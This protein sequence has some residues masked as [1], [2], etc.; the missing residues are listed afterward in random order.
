M[1]QDVIAHAI[2][3]FFSTKP[4]GA[5]TGLGLSMIYGF[6]KQSGGHLKIYSEAGVGTTVRLYLPRSPGHDTVAEDATQDGVP[7]AG[8]T[9][10]ILLVDDKAELCAIAARQLS[11][12]GYTTRIAGD[13]PA[14][15][16][17]LRS[18]ERFDLLFTDVVMPGGMNGYQLAAIARQLRPGIAVLFTTGYARAPNPGSV[19]GESPHLLSKPYHRRQ[20]AES[21]RAALTRP[22]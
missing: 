17:L 22:C 8:G 20:L 1:T 21:I 4:P 9:E 6:A 5:G 11:L 7:L 10:S 2:E 12:L 14:A 15:L 13:G 16:E 18:G 3:P 19:D